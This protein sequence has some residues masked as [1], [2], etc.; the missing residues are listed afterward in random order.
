MKAFLLA[1][2]A[3]GGIA[4][5]ANWVLWEQVPLSSAERATGTSVRLPGD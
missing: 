4:F 5:A 3:M 2:V 1:M